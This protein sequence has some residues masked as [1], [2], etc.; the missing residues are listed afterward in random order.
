MLSM[1]RKKDDFIGIRISKELKQKFQKEAKKQGLTLSEYFES[2]VKGQ[3][4]E[5]KYAVQSM[6]AEAKEKRPEYWEKTQKTPLTRDLEHL[7]PILVSDFV[8][9]PSA[10]PDG[11]PVHISYLIGHLVKSVLNNIDTVKYKGE[12]CSNAVRIGKYIAD[13]VG[14]LK[15]GDRT[16]QER[17]I[18]D[19]KEVIETFVFNFTSMAFAK[20]SF[21]TIK[22][23]L[24]KTEKI[25]LEGI[26]ENESD[27]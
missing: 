8:I 17:I 9:P 3:F 10:N 14:R 1:T 22:A 6:I 24:E 18:K 15:A 20:D 7:I 19:L 21:L 4:L 11:M 27:N 2:C 13:N 26:K 12:V 16:E 23:E 5:S 25:L